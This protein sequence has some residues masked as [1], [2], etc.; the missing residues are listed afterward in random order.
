LQAGCSEE[1]T[2]EA[3]ILHELSTIRDKA[4][5]TSLTALHKSNAPLVMALCGSK[6]ETA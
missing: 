1:E 3:N 5:K 6:G 4:G 2:L